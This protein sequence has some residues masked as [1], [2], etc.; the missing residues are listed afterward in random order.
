MTTWQH[1]HQYSEP[2]KL[3]AHVPTCLCVLT[4]S[5]GNVPCV[6]TCQRTLRAYVLTCLTCLHAH[7]LCV[8]K[9]SRAITSNNKSKFSMTCFTKIFGTFS[10]SFSWEIKLY[11]KSTYNKQECLW[12]YLLWEFNSISLNKRKTLMGAMT[13]FVQ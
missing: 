3:R 13:N 7:V 4:C 12:K 11:V 5:R 10:L 6:L 9:C 2:A 8:P 1:E